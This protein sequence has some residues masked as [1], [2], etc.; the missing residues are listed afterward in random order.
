MA[1]VKEPLHSGTPAHEL[2]CM[3]PPEA[4][5]FLNPSPVR[6]ARQEYRALF[7]NAGFKQ[8]Q[9]RRA[10]ASQR[11]ILAHDSLVNCQLC[12]HHCGVNRL[13][14]ERGPCHAGSQTRFFSAQTEV[15]DELD[16]LPCYNIALSGCDLRCDFCITGENSWN[17]NAGEPFDAREIA[18]RACEALAAGARSVML[19][20]GEPT[21]HL[22]ATL[23]F[24]AA[25]PDTAI[26]V[27]KTNAHCSRQSR[28]LL[29]GMFNVWVADFKFG[30]DGCAERLAG[31]KDYLNPVTQNL[32]WAN[33]TS[34]LI[35]RHL[36]MPGHLDC[37]WAP[38]AAWLSALLPEVEVSLRAAFWPA[39]HSYRH[40]E[41]RKT[42]SVA[43][44]EAAHAI[45]QD[46]GINLMQ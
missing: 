44:L 35:V 25:M 16:L 29:H 10:V 2:V 40:S 37:C 23:E 20:G 28:E 7:R 27:W 26:L 30:N 22:P 45:A 39:W 14:G 41:L 6:E 8:G 19:L 46:R 42:V 1:A 34:R 21:I 12:H 13:A 5:F 15:G 32:L 3:S 36:L 43:E 24:A 33:R 31:I 4:P 18:A 38:I 9:S 11:A 17:P